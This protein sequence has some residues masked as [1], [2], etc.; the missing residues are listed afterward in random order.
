MQEQ[1]PATHL[2]FGPAQTGTQPYL[3]YEVLQPRIITVAPDFK[4]G[5]M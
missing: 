2:G 4:A 1:V 3:P 5:Q